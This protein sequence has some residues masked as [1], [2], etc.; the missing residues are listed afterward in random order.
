MALMLPEAP[1]DKIMFCQS[2]GMP[3]RR[4]M[5]SAQCCLMISIPKTVINENLRHGVEGRTMLT[6]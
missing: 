6:S 5:Y 1:P 4:A 2:E 3:S